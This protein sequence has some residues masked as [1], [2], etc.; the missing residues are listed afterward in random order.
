MVTGAGPNE[1]VAANLLAGSGWS[2]EQRQTAVHVP[3]WLRLTRITR[4]A[5]PPLVLR[6]TR[7]R[8]PRLETEPPPLHQTGLL[9]PGAHP[10]STTSTGG[11]AARPVRF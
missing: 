11:A 5:I 8:L 7:S 3:R 4:V 2:M 10:D 9:G 6:T 1:P